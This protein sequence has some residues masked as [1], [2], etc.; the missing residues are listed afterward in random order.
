VRSE[1]QIMKK[2]I[3]IAIGIKMNRIEDILGMWIGEIKSA[4]F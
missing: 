1:G 4:N 3:Y 2:A